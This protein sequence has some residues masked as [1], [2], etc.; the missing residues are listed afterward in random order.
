MATTLHKGP[1]QARSVSRERNEETV[2]A[3]T[4]QANIDAAQKNQDLYSSS[5]DSPFQ[6]Q[7][8]RDEVSPDRCGSPFLNISH[9]SSRPPTPPLDQSDEPVMEVEHTDKSA[10]HTPSITLSPFQP[11]DALEAATLYNKAFAHDAIRLA[12]FPATQI[13]PSDPE[14]EVRWRATRNEIAA[15]LP[16]CRAIKAVDESA[17]GKIVGAAAWFVPGGFQWQDKEG[18]EKEKSGAGMP[19]CCDVQAHNMIMQELEDAREKLLDGN[20]NVW[21]EF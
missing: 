1:A 6:T 7:R 14:E 21:G 5:K 2:S 10:K 13:D 18:K 9:P 11:T 16:I 8:N 3:A 20:Y 19:K 15:S 12:C 17:G 4:V